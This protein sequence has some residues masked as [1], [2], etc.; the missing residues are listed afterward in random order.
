MAELSS[1][2]PSTL[3][4]VFPQI[5]HGQNFCVHS[6]QCAQADSWKLDKQGLLPKK[7]LHL[8]TNL[9]LLPPSSPYSLASSTN[10]TIP[11]DWVEHLGNILSIL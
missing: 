9:Q 11:S 8:L 2:I 10:N 7:E 4:P 1:P 5:L 6:C 3:W